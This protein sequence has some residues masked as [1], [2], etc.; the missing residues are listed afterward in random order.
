MK[1]S[2]LRY[3]DND[4]EEYSKAEQQLD[5]L[6]SMHMFLD[7]VGV[8]PKGIP[9]RHSSVWCAYICGGLKL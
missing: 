5:D 8:N 1:H 3:V 4:S 7:V 6:V 9:V 2:A